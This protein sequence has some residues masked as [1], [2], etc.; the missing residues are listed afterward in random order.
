MES[1]TYQHVDDVA[2]ALDVL[3]HEPRA[4]AIAGGTELVNWMK[5]GIVSPSTLIDINALP[6]LDHVEV[7]SGGLHIGALTRMSDVA[8]HPDV[9]RYYPAISEA[10]LQSASPQLRNMASMGGNLLQRTRCAYLRA[11]VDLPCNKRRPGSGCAARQDGGDDRT[12]AIFG[13]SEQCVSTH[14]SD[15]A[16]AL[17]ALDAVVHTQR[18]IPLRDFF[19]LPADEPERDTTLERGELIVGIQVPASAIAGRSRYL[20]VRERTSYEFAL[21]TVAIGLDLETNGRV[22]EAR[23]ALGG[24]AAMPWRLPI[25]ERAVVGAS[26]ADAAELRARVT[27]A[28]DEARPLRHNTFKVE[29]AV[30]AVVRAIQLAGQ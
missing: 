4:Y 11:E 21:V 23:I 19:R 5:E 25:A 12:A 28:F 7:S 20:K 8:A 16:V 9:Q 17:M 1:F 24:V 29:L 2:A 13:W 30:R 14:P 26:V 18:A 6:G 27:P 15:L 22:R 10:L 3:Q